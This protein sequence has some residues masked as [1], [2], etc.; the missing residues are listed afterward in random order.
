MIYF[1]TKI[2]AA[3]FATSNHHTVLMWRLIP[4]SLATPK[5]FGGDIIYK[6][7]YL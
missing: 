1:E 7:T 5:F 3:T 2:V 6:Y 4:E